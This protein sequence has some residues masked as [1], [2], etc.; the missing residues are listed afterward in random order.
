M[1]KIK[2]Q[3][4]SKGLVFGKCV[5][6]DK[7]FWSVVPSTISDTK[8]EIAKFWNAQEM[9]VHQ[10]EKLYSEA[11]LKV[12]DENAMVLKTHQIMIK[13]KDFSDKVVHYINVFKYNAKYAIYK[14]AKD[15][16]DLLNGLQSEYISQRA[17]DVKDI[18]RRLINNLSDELAGEENVN[19]FKTDFEFEKEGILLTQDVMPSEMLLL[20]KSKVLGIVTKHGGRTSHSSILAKNM[21]IPMLI[22]ADLNLKELDG[23][24]AILDGFWGEIVVE[25]NE[26]T[27][28]EYQKK[29]EDLQQ[30]KDKLRQIINLPSV[31]SDNR[32]I[33]LLANVTS[34][35]DVK[36]AVSGGAQGVGLFRSEYRYLDSAKLPSEE[37]LFESYKS[38]L[39]N[40]KNQDVVIRTIDIGSDKT[41]SC[42]SMPKEENPALGTR[43]LRLC[44]KHPDVFKTQLRALLRA[45]VYGKLSIMIPMVVSVSEV[46]R[47]KEIIDEVRLELKN[48][49]VAFENKIPLGIM[50]ETPSAVV[51]SDLLA[52]QVDFF[53]IGTNDLIQYSLACDR[54][55]V[56][57]ID[58][59]NPNN[60]AVLRMIKTVVDNAHKNKIW[61]EVCGDAAN[62][63]IMI[64]KMIGLGVDK[65]SVDID[66]LLMVK[67]KIINTS[68]EKSRKTIL[69]LIY[70]QN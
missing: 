66:N 20:D 67:N 29:Q 12:T 2:C 39:C 41:V 5:F 14:A 36:D 54:N 15:Y 16:I 70:P 23:K 10:L 44:F 1:K 42:I 56:G 32:N 58:I 53:S 8:K 55:N 19:D 6:V 43:A 7:N 9:S 25:P 68:Y 17:D 21:K 11:V 65:F 46:I 49:G 13:D 59:Y 34:Q 37:E 38:A 57:L 63:L 31:T 62:D 48:K 47:V 52:K 51:I 33:G 40:A 22:G 64:D 45:S 69:K 4:A 50:I 35:E 60:I 24:F 61:V 27:I 3:V 26:Q 30:T 18:M 28:V